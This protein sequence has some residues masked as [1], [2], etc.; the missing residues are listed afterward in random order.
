VAGAKGVGWEVVGGGPVD[1]PGGG[2]AVYLRS[3]EDGTT[4]ELFE[5]VRRNRFMM[6]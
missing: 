3:L 1:M 6:R 4:V 5:G 2:R